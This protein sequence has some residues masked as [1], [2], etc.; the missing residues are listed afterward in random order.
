[1]EDRGKGERKRYLL[2]ANSK[3]C[4]QSSQN[5][6]PLCFSHCT[7]LCDDKHTNVSVYAHFSEEIH[8]TSLN[9]RLISLPVLVYV[10]DAASAEARVKQRTLWLS[11]CTTN[12]TDICKQKKL[13]LIVVLRL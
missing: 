9:F 8:K 11:W 4:L 5:S 3:R 6:F 1:M 12:S 13:T 10:F 7:K 2:G